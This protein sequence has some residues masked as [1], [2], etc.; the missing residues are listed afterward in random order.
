MF[1]QPYWPFKQ[2]LQ[3]YGHV[4]ILPATPLFTL[5]LSSLV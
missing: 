4:K 1:I 5:T 2:H 3:G